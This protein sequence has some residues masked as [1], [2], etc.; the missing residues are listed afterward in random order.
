M[1]G[2]FHPDDVP[3]LKVLAAGREPVTIHMANVRARRL[4]VYSAYGPTEATICVTTRAVT[5]DMDLRNIGSSFHHVAALAPDPD[6]MEV[7]SNGDVR[8]AVR[9]Q[10]PNH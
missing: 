3:T 1:A 8:R 2:L 7:V 9:G 5:P 4:Q 6:T 10:A